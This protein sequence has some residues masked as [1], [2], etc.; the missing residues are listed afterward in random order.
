MLARGGYQII[1]GTYNEN[2]AYLELSNLIEKCVNSGKPVYFNNVV[3]N[4]TPSGGSA[5]TYKGAG[6]GQ[7]M[8]NQ[9]VICYKDSEG[10]YFNLTTHQFV[11]L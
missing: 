6:F 3:V 7:R 11:V 10:L 9:I 8:N 1:E 5:T 4:Y 2:T